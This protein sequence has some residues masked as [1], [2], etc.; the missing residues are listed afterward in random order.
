MPRTLESVYERFVPCEL[1]LSVSRAPRVGRPVCGHRLDRRTRSAT[2]HRCA[3]PHFPRERRKRRRNELIPI[4]S[5]YSAPAAP[6]PDARAPQRCDREHRRE[7]QLPCLTEMRGDRRRSIG[8]R[9]VARVEG[10]ASYP[11]RAFRTPHLRGAGDY[12]GGVARSP[13]MEPSPAR[14]LTTAPIM[15]RYALRSVENVRAP[16]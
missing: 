6:V 11:R 7:Q 8:Q 2:S 10:M 9:E 15:R 16:A 5:Q 4:A 12:R 1:V 3:L 13:A 14:I